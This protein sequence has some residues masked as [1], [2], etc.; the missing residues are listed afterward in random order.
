MDPVPAVVLFGGPLVA[1]EFR[2]ASTFACPSAF[3]ASTSLARFSSA[4]RARSSF[5]RNF[6]Y[7]EVSMNL[8]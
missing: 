8:D 7:N 3:F 1:R 6:G 4:I 5:D 2:T